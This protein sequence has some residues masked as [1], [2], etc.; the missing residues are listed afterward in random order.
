MSG[1]DKYLMELMAYFVSITSG[2]WDYYL[3]I[4]AA[5]V[6]ALSSFVIELKALACFLT[7]TT[8]LCCSLVTSASVSILNS[9]RKINFIVLKAFRAALGLLPRYEG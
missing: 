6:L 3:Q 7:V 1:T 2:A 8:H 5:R 4:F 9:S